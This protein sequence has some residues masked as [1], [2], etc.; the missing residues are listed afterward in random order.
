MPEESFQVVQ[1]V[2]GTHSIHA[3]AEDETFHPVIGPA[4][5]AQTLYVEQLK[6]PQRIEAQEGDFVIWDVGLGGAANVLA[7][8]AAAHPLKRSIHVLSFDRTTAPL[9]FALEHANELEYMAP[10]QSHVKDLLSRQQTTFCEDQLSVQWELHLGD[11]PTLIDR[12]TFTPPHAIL[13]DAYSPAKNPAMWTAPLFA[14]IFRQLDPSKPCAMPTYSRSTM[15]RVA[16]LLAGF[17]VGMGHATGEKEQTTI[18]ANTLSLIDEP[19]PRA[20]LRRAHNS[21]SAEPLWDGVYRQ[22]PISEKTWNRLI[23]HPQFK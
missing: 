15:L 8:F 6:L 21:R 3:E 12:Q 17:Y 10:H 14:K 1:L 18:A 2:N 13:F 16:L 22:A 23:N 11:F 5:E 19:L 9:A 20:W 4:A 7:V